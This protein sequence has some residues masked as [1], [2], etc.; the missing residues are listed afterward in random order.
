[1][2]NTTL[3]SSSWLIIAIA[4]ASLLALVLPIDLGPDE[5]PRMVEDAAHGPLFALAA[6]GILAVLRR[7]SHQTAA[8]IR[9]YTLAFAISVTLGAAGELAQLFTETRHAQMK[10]LVTDICGVIAGLCL[11]PDT[12]SA[13][14]CARG[15][16]ACS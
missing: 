3:A 10:D 5:L 12:T 7:E 15:K 11:S 6:I 1:M 16:S 2:P 9:L 8:A 14:S 4:T 13:C